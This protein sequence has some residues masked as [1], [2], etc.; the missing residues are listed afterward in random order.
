MEQ[1]RQNV[2]LCPGMD[3]EEVLAVQRMAQGTKGKS[4]KRNE[5]KREKKQADGLANQLEGLRC[6]IRGARS[7]RRPGNFLGLSW[8]NED[9]HEGKYVYLVAKAFA[10]RAWWLVE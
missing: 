10:L 3:N 4:A 5:K 8:L 7:V 6:A 2:P 1:T 9:M